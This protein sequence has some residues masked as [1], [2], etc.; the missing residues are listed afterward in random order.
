MNA[1][2]GI[3]AVI[4]ALALPTDARVEQRVPKKLLLE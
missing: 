1:E 4:A 3:E 2:S